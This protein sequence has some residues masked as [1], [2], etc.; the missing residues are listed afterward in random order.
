MKKFIYSK[1]KF[2]NYIDQ[3]KI[4]IVMQNDLTIYG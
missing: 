1:S 2:K 3:K 4:K